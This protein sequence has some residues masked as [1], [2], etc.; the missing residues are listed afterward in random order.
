MYRLRAY[1]GAAGYVAANLGAGRL[2]GS[3]GQKGDSHSESTAAGT[4]AGREKSESA[5]SD[6]AE[7]NG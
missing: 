1:Q 3:E 5:L 2:E 4:E 6:E 7:K